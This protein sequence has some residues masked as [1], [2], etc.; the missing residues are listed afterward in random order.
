MSMFDKD[1]EI[2]RN[3]T[4][5]FSAQEEFVLLGVRVEEEKVKTDLGMA[6]KSTLR[7]RRM[8]SNEEFDV[9]SLGKAIANKCKEAEDS[10]FPAVVCWLT[11]PSKTYQSNATVL[12]FIR[13]A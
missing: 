1:K 5:V 10:D 7:V 8:N 13:P 4:T 3:L 6:D 2:G 12:Q 11:V 9:T